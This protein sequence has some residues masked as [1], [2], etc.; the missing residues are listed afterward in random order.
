MSQQ[1]S[2]GSS[3]PVEPQTTAIAESERRSKWKMRWIAA[4]LATLTMLVVWK[5][6]SAHPY[7]D[8]D[9]PQ[10]QALADGK[11]TMKPFA[12]QGS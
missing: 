10:Y 12:L 4:V 7:I 5:M 1:T 2:M 9:S 8:P 11:P 6:A 3:K